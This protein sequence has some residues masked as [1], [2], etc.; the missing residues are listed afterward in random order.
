MSSSCFQSGVDLSQM[1]EL[2]SLTLRKTTFYSISLHCLEDCIVF[3]N[4][5]DF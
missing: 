2:N 3:Q 1:T 5:S 4:Y